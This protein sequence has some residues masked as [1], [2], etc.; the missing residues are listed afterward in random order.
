MCG[1][2]GVLLAETDPSQVEAAVEI[3]E[4]LFYLQHRGQDACGIATCGAG[5]RIFQC[6]GNGMAAQE[7][8][9]RIPVLTHFKLTESGL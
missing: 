5:G 1:I 8:W 6:K 3:H 7:S 4:T 9:A 2:V